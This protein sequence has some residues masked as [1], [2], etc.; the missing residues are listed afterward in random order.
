LAPAGSGLAA[1]RAAVAAARDEATTSTLPNGKPPVTSTVAEP[2]T[3]RAPT[4][5]VASGPED[6]ALV[7]RR[8][9][10][11][12][13]T[14]ERRRVT[15]TMVKQ[16]GQVASVEG[17]VLKLAFDNPALAARFGAGSHAENVALAVRETLGLHVRVEG[18]VGPF[19][20]VTAP[21]AAAPYAESRGA[22]GSPSEPPMADEPPT[23][24][25]DMSADDAEAP[26]AHLS[27]ADVIASMLGGTIVDD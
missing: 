1:A 8:W 18:V 14:L 5:D 11:V 6:A 27:G 4:G 7:R 2:D 24:E 22:S 21:T 25:E 23:E 26:S 12:L 19:G 9:D 13:G 3:V 10:E 15:W 20:G 17:G 16:S